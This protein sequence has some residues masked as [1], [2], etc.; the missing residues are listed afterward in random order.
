[1]WIWWV[2]MSNGGPLR[3]EWINIAAEKKQLGKTFTLS[4]STPPLSG[5]EEAREEEDDDTMMRNSNDFQNGDSGS[6]G[7]F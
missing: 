7:K 6:G 2:R 4:L 3:P 1:M 5:E